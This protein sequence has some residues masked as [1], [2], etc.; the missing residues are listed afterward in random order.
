ME[1]EEIE[2]TEE[3][4]KTENDRNSTQENIEKS[5]R[6]I[7]FNTEAEVQGDLDQT[8]TQN[9]DRIY[10]INTKNLP[11]DLEYKREPRQGLPAKFYPASVEDSEKYELTNQIQTCKKLIKKENLSIITCV[12]KAILTTVMNS[13]AD[14]YQQNGYTIMEMFFEN[15]DRNK[16]WKLLEDIIGKQFKW[17]GKLLLFVRDTGVW[18]VNKPPKFMRE[19][20][21]IDEYLR[22]GINGPLQE[23]N[24]KIVYFSG[25]TT[26]TKKVFQQYHIPFLLPF[27]KFNE[28]SELLGRIQTLKINKAIPESEWELL[29]CLKVVLK[30]DDFEVAVDSYEI[31]KNVFIEALNREGIYPIVLFIGAFFRGLEFDEFQRFLFLLIKQIAKPK[32]AEKLIGQ[33]HSKADKI[34]KKISLD[35][36]DQTNL[37]R[38]DFKLEVDAQCCM[39]VLVEERRV[40][41]EKMANIIASPVFFFYM[42]FRHSTMQKVYA[43]LATFGKSYGRY[44]KYEIPVKFL[45]VIEEKGR[46]LRSLSRTK[47]EAQF[48]YHNI[49]KQ[50]ER[51]KSLKNEEASVQFLKSITPLR[52]SNSTLDKRIDELRFVKFLM[53]REVEVP[54]G[55]ETQKVINELRLIKKEAAEILEQANKEW[56]MMNSEHN[57]LIRRFSDLIV[58]LESGSSETVNEILDE[59]ISRQNKY[60]SIFDILNSIHYKSGKQV[61]QWYLKSLASSEREER[62]RAVIGVWEL[63]AYDETNFFQLF[64]EIE[65]HLP[66]DKTTEDYSQLEKQLVVIILFNF[67]NQISKEFRF[68][69]KLDSITNEIFKNSLFNTEKEQIEEGLDNLL[70]LLLATDYSKIIDDVPELY[71]YFYQT[72]PMVLMVEILFYW[73]VLLTNHEE[74][75]LVQLL[76]QGLK[77]VL[78]KKIINKKFKHAKTTILSNYNQAIIQ[79]VVHDQRTRS[80]K[81]RDQFKQFAKLIL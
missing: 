55:F 6:D 18:E 68:G 66:V 76:T 11:N 45:Q 58:E 75:D 79:S 35:N 44:Y 26:Y 22:S 57:H 19:L 42:K 31:N 61:F 28:K 15:Y 33:W 7:H 27:L 70:Q 72:D 38:I 60:S 43:F 52:I 4:C 23:S 13:I 30:A 65:P 9:G 34:L 12:D 71:G 16:V 46:E 73:Y 54:E 63:L 74:E 10:Y 32:K 39:N 78:T 77:S 3:N 47:Q 81:K 14:E 51:F 56:N 20:N 21:L 59:A 62:E 41:V 5:N 69:D 37:R 25:S 48:N 67:D 17:S 80:T 1:N 40:L 53:Y 36:R 50:L 64:S 49:K 2:T 8:V 29:D 24:S